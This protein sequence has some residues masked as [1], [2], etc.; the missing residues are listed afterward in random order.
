MRIA[1]YIV[2]FTI[3]A[4][5]FEALF[6]LIFLCQP[7]SAFWTETFIFGKCH[8]FRLMLHISTVLNIVTHVLIILLPIPGLKQL[9]LPTSQKIGLIVVFSLGFG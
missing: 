1:I 4:Y 6:T 3:V 8:N 9:V 7:V 2:I 5:L